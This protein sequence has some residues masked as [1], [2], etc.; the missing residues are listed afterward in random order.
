MFPNATTSQIESWCVM[1][2]WH[3]GSHRMM[4]YTVVKSVQAAWHSKQWRQQYWRNPVQPVAFCSD[5]AAEEHRDDAAR[6]NSSNDIPT[7]FE[8]PS[9]L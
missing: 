9:V 2:R 3:V 1:Q 7:S 8:Q 5:R 6:Q 4:H